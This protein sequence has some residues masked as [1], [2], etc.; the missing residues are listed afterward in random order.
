[1][2]AH[3]T[4]CD[5][6]S[7]CALG[8]I[9][10]E[11]SIPELRCGAVVGSANNQ[12]ATDRDANRIQA[13]GILYAPDYVVN[14]GGVINIPEEQGGYDRDRA[15]KRIEGIYETTIQILDLAER[16]GITTAEAADRYAEARIEAA[17]AR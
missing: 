15:N 3:A 6:F 14:A 10:N 1:D 7:P 16:D 4:E 9:L 17:R 2:T 13:A 12:L 11:R 8:A 5:V